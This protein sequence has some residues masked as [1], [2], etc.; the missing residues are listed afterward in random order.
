[1]FR[2]FNVP[3]EIIRYHKTPP[4]FFF[5]EF[6]IE[7]E[8][9]VVCWFY[10]LSGEDL[11][12]ISVFHSFFFSPPLSSFFFLWQEEWGENKLIN[13]FFILF[14]VVE[15]E[16]FNSNWNMYVSMNI[17]VYM[18]RCFV[19]FLECSIESN[20]TMS[21]IKC[22]WYMIFWDTLFRF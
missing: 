8:Q 22:V 2:V 4:S 5:S 10:L 7:S 9:L 19:L 15:R 12:G 1:M 17:C 14:E 6:F 21:W 16:C 20:I 3:R 18:Y 13:P 11:W